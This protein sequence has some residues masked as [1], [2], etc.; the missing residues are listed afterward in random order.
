[1]IKSTA[2]KNLLREY[3]N[4]YYATGVNAKSPWDNRYIKETLEKS[5][6]PYI[7]EQKIR[8][9]FDNSSNS[10][11]KKIGYG[12]NFR[13]YSAVWINEIIANMNL[14]QFSSPFKYRPNNRG[15]AV[16]NLLARAL[17][18]ND[19][20]FYKLSLPGEGYP[21]D[22]LQESAIWA[23]A[24]VYIIGE[25]SDKQWLLVLTSSYIAWVESDRIAKTSESF[26]KKWQQYAKQ[27]MVAIT[28]NKLSIFDLENQYRFNA[29]IGAVF[30]GKNINKNTITVLIPI[31]DTYHRAKISFARLNKKDAKIMP[32]EATPHNFVTI[33][34]SLLGR[35]YGWG[36]MYFYN[37]CSA[38]LQSLYTP[39]GIWLPRNSSAQINARE[40]ID[41]SENSMEEHLK[42][43]LENGKKF[44]TIIYIGAHTITY[45]GKY[46]NPNSAAHEPIALT[47]Q[48]VWGNLKPADGSYRAVV[49]K[50][51]LLPLL[52]KYP[53]DPK[54]NSQANHKY[55]QISFLDKTMIQE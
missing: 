37:D 7:L 25:T 49:G 2:Q 55:F 28:K 11:P 20:F 31:A 51:V 19:P 34:S 40:K 8:G 54:I 16:R 41:L 44:I 27:K 9:S 22:N 45:M 50:S 12:V 53:E 38:E 15:I 30:P 23:G 17:P 48:N 29:Y 46:P 6:A 14:K 36:G 1:M 35:P 24:P 3:Y 32:L 5:L 4:H 42:H 43:L 18:T 33:M 52:T 26:I 47:F 21:F 13:P 10:N 39:F